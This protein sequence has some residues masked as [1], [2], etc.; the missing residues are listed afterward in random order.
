MNI[1]DVVIEGMTSWQAVFLTFPFESGHN[2][3]NT[4]PM[5]VKIAGL[6]IRCLVYIPL[7]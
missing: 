5:L 2:E 6:F 1:I 7:I 3:S 4:N